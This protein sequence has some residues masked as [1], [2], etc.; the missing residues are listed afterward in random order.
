MAELQL[1]IRVAGQ[2]VVRSR[3]NALIDAVADLTPAMEAMADYIQEEID[4]AFETS[5]A[6]TARG[7]WA[8][9]DG[10]YEALKRQLYPGAPLL[11]AT[12]A[13]RRS[14][15]QRSAK[16]S[17]RRISR[18]SLEVGSSIRVGS[19]RRWNLGQ[20]HQLGTRSYPPR[21]IIDLTQR[22]RRRLLSIVRTHID[23]RAGSYRPDV[24]RD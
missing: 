16:G 22:Q 6:S 9:L 8:P 15:T 1:S 11:V 18:R 5:G 13:L 14:L 20:L 12:G 2:A 7:L 3:V 24:A 4:E 10:G 19:I 23:K 21:P 17:I